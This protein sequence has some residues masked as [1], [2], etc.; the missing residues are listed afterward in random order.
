MSRYIH[1]QARVY[2]GVPF[3]VSHFNRKLQYRVKSNLPL[4][5]CN[6]EGVPSAATSVGRDP[7]F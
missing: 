6:H 7:D 5:N 2:K 3:N 1:G 4:L